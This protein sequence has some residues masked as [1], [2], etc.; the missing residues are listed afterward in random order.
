MY[1]L[2]GQKWLY[3]IMIIYIYYHDPYPSQ[4]AL[5]FTA[6]LILIITARVRPY[7]YNCKW[8][9]FFEVLILL[10]L[11]L[12]SAYFLDNEQLLDTANN[13]FAV[14]LLVLPFIYCGLYILFKIFYKCR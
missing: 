7:A 11:V 1:K 10:D 4:I 13:D 5:T 8:V 9:N 6:L 12:L 2:V 14:L 3:I